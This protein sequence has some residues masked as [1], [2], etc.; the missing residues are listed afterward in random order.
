ML[1]V[2]TSAFTKK[3]K[4]IDPRILA[5]LRE[6]VAIFRKDQRHP[7]LNNHKLSGARKHQR[8]INITGDWRLIFEQIDQETIRLIDIDT[9]TNLYGK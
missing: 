5:P 7:I 2:E 1:I 4:R 9:H 6:R 8:S 3:L